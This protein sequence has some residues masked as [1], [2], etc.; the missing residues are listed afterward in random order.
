MQGLIRLRNEFFEMAGKSRFKRIAIISLFIALIWIG[1]DYFVYDNL[2][3]NLKHDLIVLMLGIVV[4]RL[5]PWGK[6]SA[7]VQSAEV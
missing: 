3:M 4:E 5:L 1:V 7:P 6:M 2:T